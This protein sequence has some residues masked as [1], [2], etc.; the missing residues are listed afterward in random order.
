M[1]T[2][3]IQSK[4]VKIIAHRGVS[5]LERENTTPAFIAAGNRSYFGI[6]TDIQVISDGTFVAMHDD[7]TKRVCLGKFNVDVKGGTWE[8]LKSVVL[9]DLDGSFDRQDIRIPTL[10][11]YVKICKKYGKMCILEVK[12]V[13]RV[14]D[15]I[16][17]IDE[18]KSLDYLDG[19]IF[20]SIEYENCVNLRALLPNAKIQYLTGQ[21]MD[22]TVIEMLTSI[23]VDAGIDIDYQNPSRN[24]ERIELLH[25][26]GIEV[27]VCTCDDPKLAREL[28]AMGADYLTSNILE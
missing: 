8:S 11:D 20:I 5:K 19:V 1:D 17:M 6:E 7:D 10:A 9:P 12:N 21:K 23:H 15:L 2:I 26:L 16:R 22:D 4:N 3:K 28:I 27:N 18:I 24:K 25:S 13:F 14:D